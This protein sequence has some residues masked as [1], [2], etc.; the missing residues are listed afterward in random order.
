ME[1]RKRTGELRRAKLERR[2]FSRR[3]PNERRQL[4]AEKHVHKILV[5][6]DREWTDIP[7]VVDELRNYRPGTILVH[8]ACRGADIICAAVAEALRFEVRGY[9]ADWTTFKRAAGPIRNQQMLDVEN[10]PDEPIDLCLAFH[11]NIDQSRGTADML[12]R[13][14]KATIVW[15]LCTTE[16]TPG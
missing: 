13:V 1:P 8:G 2:Y 16:T 3:E 14:E 4:P 11:N 15:K 12:R 9:P 10:R 6:G 5:T 7:R